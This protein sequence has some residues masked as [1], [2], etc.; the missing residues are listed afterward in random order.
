MLILRLLLPIFLA[1]VLL[2]A[3]QGGVL[4]A[5]HHSLVELSQQHNKQSPHEPAD[6]EQCT[7]FAQLG[8]ALNSG[9]L[10]IE[11]HSLLAQTHAQRRYVF[12]T[13]HTLTATAR[14]PPV[15]PLAI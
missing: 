12:H 3:Q 9:Y 11:L 1:L 8:S 2:F 13:Q 5:L 7:S 10:S 4:H 15:F 14:G 6:C